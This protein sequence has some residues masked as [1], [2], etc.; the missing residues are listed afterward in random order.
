ME[1]KEE[2][3]PTTTNAFILGAEFIL[4]KLE[5]LGDGGASQV[6]TVL[7]GEIDLIKQ[8]KNQLK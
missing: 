6:G 5:K 4:K 2:M 7:W 3:D 8:L 1:I